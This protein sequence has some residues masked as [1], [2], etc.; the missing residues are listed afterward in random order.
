M[1]SVY[2]HCV[3]ICHSTV[4]KNWIH[5]YKG[6]SSPKPK[7]FPPLLSLS[8]CFFFFLLQVFDPLSPDTTGLQVGV[9]VWPWS[10]RCLLKVS[11]QLKL[12]TYEKVQPKGFRTNREQLINHLGNQKKTWWNTWW[13]TSNQIQR[14]IWFSQIY[15]MNLILRSWSW[16]NQTTSRAETNHFH[17]QL[18]C[19]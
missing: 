11:Q 7:S 13:N 1:L 8:V 5:K 19:C 3:D 18:I 17:Y 9:R 15:I 12:V 6:F 4:W 16:V 14:C 2:F 10:T